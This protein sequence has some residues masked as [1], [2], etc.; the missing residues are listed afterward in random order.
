MSISNPREHVLS[1][2]RLLPEKCILPEHETYL[3]II[4]AFTFF[5]V[6]ALVLGSV[7]E[8]SILRLRKMASVLLEDDIDRSSIY[9]VRIRLVTS[10][11]PFQQTCKTAGKLR[12]LVLRTAFMSNCSQNIES[13]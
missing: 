2:A 5:L 7:F 10:D 11:L 3:Q 12:S 13:E 9:F 4:P 8:V 6:F 1:T